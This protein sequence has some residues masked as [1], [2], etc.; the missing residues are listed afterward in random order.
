[1]TTYIEHPSQIPTDKVLELI[2]LV[3][4]LDIRY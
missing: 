3:R 4:W 2:N 1:M